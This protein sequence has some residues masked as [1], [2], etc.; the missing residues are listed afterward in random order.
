[1]PRRLGA[2][3]ITLGLAALAGGV[4][5]E[6][7]AAQ[8]PAHLAGGFTQLF[9]SPC[10]EPYRGK[11]GE[12]Y[13]VALWFKQADLNHDGVITREEF[14]ADHKGFFEALDYDDA[15]VLDGPKIAFYEKKVLPDVFGNDRISRL[16]PPAGAL[17]AGVVLAGDVPGRDGAELIR[18]QAGS[19]AGQLGGPTNQ[20]A[21]TVQG[22]KG[23]LA[24][25][26][27]QRKAPRELIGAASYGLLAEVE[28]IRAA[29]TNLDGLVTKE[30]FLAAADRRFNLLDK[31]HDGRLTLDEL[32]QTATQI[33]LA[34]Q[35][36]R[37]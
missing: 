5:A 20:D 26:N 27:A 28:P 16:E 10:G 34:K 17:K 18:V 33:E 2:L 37:R 32:P 25:L 4:T 12:P 24:G 9:I 6:R 13:P 30:E 1:M 3:T 7:S 14:R 21:E 22:A 23:P 19:L 35:G 36:R 31:R 11:P 8:G 15:G 29:D